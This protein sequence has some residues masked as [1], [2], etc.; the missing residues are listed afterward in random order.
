MPN[1]PG[2]EDEEDNGMDK[3]VKGGGFPGLHP[4]VP[5]QQIFQAMCPKGAEPDRSG[6]DDAG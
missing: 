2:N 5:D 6:A 4:S 3:V 1:L